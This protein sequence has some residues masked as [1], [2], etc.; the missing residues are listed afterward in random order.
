MY[1]LILLVTVVQYFLPKLF[2]MQ[3]V[4]NDVPYVSEI[5]QT[6]S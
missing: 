6:N 3:K 5:K 4:L 1:Y 2:K